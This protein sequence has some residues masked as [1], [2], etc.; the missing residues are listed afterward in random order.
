MF[1]CNEDTC[2]VD[3]S[4]KS[5]DDIWLSNPTIDEFGFG[6]TVEDDELMTYEILKSSATPHYFVMRL[7]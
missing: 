5:F 6:I 2:F 4:E 3:L 7:C 1:L